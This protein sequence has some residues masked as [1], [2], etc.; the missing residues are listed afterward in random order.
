LKVIFH[1]KK[2][3]LSRELLIKVGEEEMRR[4]SKQDLDIG[5][6]SGVPMAGRRH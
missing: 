2:H 5:V 4:S 3:S 1:K 6:E